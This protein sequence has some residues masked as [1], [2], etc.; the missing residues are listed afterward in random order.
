MFSLRINCQFWWANKNS[1]NNLYVSGSPGNPN[2]V[3]VSHTF[4]LQVLGTVFDNLWLLGGVYQ[5]Y[6]N[7]SEIL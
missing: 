5:A 7:L 6:S 2:L 1:I 3:E 4:G